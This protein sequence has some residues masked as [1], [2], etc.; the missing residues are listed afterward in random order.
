M[1]DLL[2]E[3]EDRQERIP[4]YYRIFALIRFVIICFLLGKLP[5]TFNNLFLNLPEYTAEAVGQFTGGI[6]VLILFVFYIIYFIQQGLREFSLKQSAFNKSKIRW[7][8]IFFSG[9]TTGLF[10]YNLVRYPWSNFGYSFLT[11]TYWIN[12]T[13]A[14]VILIVDISYSIRLKRKTK[15]AV[16]LKRDGLE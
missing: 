14:F 2:K 6:I 15:K 1:E 8:G 13:M 12:V 5:R 16:T 4:A 3:F 9:L 11:I 10:L 7:I